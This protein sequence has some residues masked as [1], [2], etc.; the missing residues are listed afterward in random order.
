MSPSQ[1]RPRSENPKSERLYIR[2]TPNEKEE[3]QSFANNHGMTLLEIMRIGMDV[4]RK[5]K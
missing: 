3:I 1:G 2:I 5:R 4:V